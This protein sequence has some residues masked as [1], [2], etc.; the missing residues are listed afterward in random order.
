MLGKRNML[1]GRVMKIGIKF[2]LSLRVI[3]AISIYI[4]KNKAVTVSAMS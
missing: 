3:I 2:S 4:I 1:K